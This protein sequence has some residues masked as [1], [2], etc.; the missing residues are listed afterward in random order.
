MIKHLSL[1]VLL[2][3][4]FL[5]ARAQTTADSVAKR[6]PIDSAKS[7]V[8]IDTAKKA[9]PSDSLIKKQLMETVKA[10]PSDS[11]LRQRHADS[12]KKRAIDSVAKAQAADSLIK[13]LAADSLLKKSHADSVTLIKPADSASKMTVPSTVV[14]TDSVAKSNPPK[15]AVKH[16][17]ADSVSHAT[18]VKA[19]IVVK[20]PA[21]IHSPIKTLSDKKYFGYLNGDDMDDMSL[22]GELNHYP[23]PDKALKYKAQL[24][25]NP[26]QITKLKDIVANLTR[27]RKEM[28][29]NIV[30]N[31]K[32]LDTLFKSRQIVDGTV[33]FYTNRYGLYLGELRNAILQACL[34]TQDILSDVQ[35][36]KLESLEK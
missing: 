23:M 5:G 34:K 14:K 36:K 10:L 22:V 18:K 33:I 3:F 7:V 35:I 20:P 30:K 32:T 26:G 17:N 31:E 9:T 2:L 11:V 12:L 27:K 25:L 16:I 21:P 1:L 29:E 24:Q 19:A 13:K 4:F 15:I 6:V 8:P 28:G